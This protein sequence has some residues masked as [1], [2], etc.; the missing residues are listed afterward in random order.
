MKTYQSLILAS[1]LGLVVAGCSQESVDKAEEKTKESAATAAK[2][3][4][5]AGEKAADAT[6]SFGEK[7]AGKTAEVAGKAAG[8]TKEIAGKTADATKEMAGKVATKTKE[9]SEATAEAIT[10]GWI[11][12]KITAK[13]AD[14]TIL[15]GH[16]INVDTNDHVVT[17][18]GTV[19]TA[20]AKAKAES[21][22]KG[23]KGVTRVVNQ[24][25]VK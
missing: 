8:E 11:T 4:E 23:T 7:V 16:R 19:R 2:E 17:L 6:K 21:I 18:K 15:E 22:A 3:T 14:E 9:V 5:A 24:I 20:A 13:F 10:D 1:L 25:V 12:T